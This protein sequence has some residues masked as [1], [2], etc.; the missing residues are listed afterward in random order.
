MFLGELCESDLKE[1]YFC[2]F[3][4]SVKLCVN[5]YVIVALS[6]FNN[7]S[8]RLSGRLILTGIDRED[9]LGEKAQLIN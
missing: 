9:R 5:P 6:Y 1:R 2:Y 3:I 4:I 7:D 8:S